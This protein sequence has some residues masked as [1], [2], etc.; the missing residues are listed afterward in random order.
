V[1]RTE[2]EQP[3]HDSW[4]YLTVASMMWAMRALDHMDA[5]HPHRSLLR[6]IAKRLQTS[7]TLRLTQAAAERERLADQVRR[8]AARKGPR[9]KQRNEPERR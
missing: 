2:P 8:R 5:D 9:S 3:Q 6:D 1:L 4:L 7:P